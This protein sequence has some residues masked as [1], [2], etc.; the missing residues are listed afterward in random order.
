ML[1]RNFAPEQD[2]SKLLRKAGEASG[3]S[4]QIYLKEAFTQFA[5]ELV[6]QIVLEKHD[7]KA[8]RIFRF[9]NF[10]LVVILCLISVLQVN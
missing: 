2:N 6:E 10:L 9:L 8:A 5:W 7:S 4:Y 3:G 1:N